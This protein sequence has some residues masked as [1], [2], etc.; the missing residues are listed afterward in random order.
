MNQLRSTETVAEILEDQ[1][2]ADPYVD[3]VCKAYGQLT[4][5]EL[6][7]KIEATKNVP[8]FN[9]HERELRWMTTTK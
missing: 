9:R 3:Y 2:T 8:C 6:L 4:I 5:P 7:G 1:Q